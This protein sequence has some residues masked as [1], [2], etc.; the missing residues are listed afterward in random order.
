MKLHK[1]KSYKEYLCLS[2]IKILKQYNIVT[3]IYLVVN[4]GQKLFQL[5]IEIKDQ[6]HTHIPTSIHIS[7]VHCNLC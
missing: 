7:I 2:E 3:S 4:K 5:Y 1:I 6:I